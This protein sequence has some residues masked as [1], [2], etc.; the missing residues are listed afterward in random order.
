MTSAVINADAPIAYRARWVFPIDQPPLDG[1]IVTIVGGRIAA[2]GRNDTGRP[3]HDLGDVALL[4]GL[5]NAHT[6]LEFS[7]L[8]RPLGRPGMPFAD[9]IGEVVSNRRQSSPQS[10]PTAVQKGVTESWNAGVTALGEIATPGWTHPPTAPGEQITIVAFLELLGLATGQTSRLLQLAEQHLQ[11]QNS[12]ILPALSPHAPYT[13]HPDLLRAACKLSASQQVPLAMH[14]AET[15]EELELLTSHSGPLVELLQSLNAWFPDVLPKGLRPL[16][17]LQT[18]A[19]AHRALVVHG[20]YLAQDE[21]DF[22]AAHRDR[23]SLVYC[24]RTHAY[25][26]HE[27]YPLSQMLTAGA[28][29]AVGTDSRASSPDLN[30]FEELRHMA[31]HHHPTVAPDHILHMGTLAGAQALGL[32]GK[33]GSITPGKSASMTVVPLGEARPSPYES[34]FTSLSGSARPLAQSLA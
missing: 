25:F 2:V 20:N 12:Q 32:A 23:L 21:I 24:P 11:Q 1:G 29:I 5:V 13:V 28:R 17:Y 15:R 22:V 7:L 34:L 3:P 10:L 6:H 19:T 18:L 4:P 8:D 26:D 27:P 16:D 14:L 9:W 30:L 33:F 31:H